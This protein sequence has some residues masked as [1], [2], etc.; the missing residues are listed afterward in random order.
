M[1][2]RCEAGADGRGKGETLITDS[3]RARL[4]DEGFTVIESL[5]GPTFTIKPGARVE[6]REL[7]PFT[8]QVISPLPRSRTGAEIFR[9]VTSAILETITEDRAEAEGVLPIN[10]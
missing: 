10:A 5:E 4:L 3:L 1:Q 9:D 6:V 2:S 7:A 8:T